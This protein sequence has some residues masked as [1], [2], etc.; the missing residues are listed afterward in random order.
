MGRVQSQDPRTPKHQPQHSDRMSQLEKDMDEILDCTIKEML[1]KLR[2]FSD[3]IEHINR[4]FGSL[5][6]TGGTLDDF[7]MKV[8]RY[9]TEMVNWRRQVKLG[10]V[11]LPPLNQQA[12]IDR[13][14]IP[15][16]SGEHSTLSRFLK[17]FYTRALSSQSEDALNHSRRR[18]IMSGDN[19]RRGLEREYGR[20]IVTQ[21]LTVWNG[22]TKA[23]EKDTTVAHIVVGAKAPSS[24]WKILKSMVDDDSSER[25]REQA[26]KN[27]EGL[28]IDNS[29][30]M[31]EYIARLKF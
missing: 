9:E 15:I 29:E 25:A 7:R 14:P 3:E 8:D 26:K 12:R 13:F 19:L 23:V 16:Y 20:P 4:M 24:A 22:L 17:L 21:S 6:R 28:C 27:F 2:R 11:P 5:D 31:K 18:I 1:E 10:V 30:S